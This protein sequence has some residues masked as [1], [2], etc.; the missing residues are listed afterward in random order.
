VKIGENARKT[1]I[2]FYNWSKTT[3]GIEQALKEIISSD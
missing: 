2:E 3:N 1:I